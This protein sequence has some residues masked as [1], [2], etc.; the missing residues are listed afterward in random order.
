MPPARAAHEPPRRLGLRGPRG[1][2]EPRCP[3]QAGA[4]GSPW[5][6]PPARRSPAPSGPGA[7]PR[8]ALWV[9]PPLRNRFRMAS[10]SPG[11][12]ATKLPRG[13]SVL[14][15]RT[16]SGPPAVGWAHAA[17]VVARR[18][19][20][21]TGRPAAAEG[22]S[23]ENRLQGRRHPLRP[24]GRPAL[25]RHL[26][27]L[28]PDKQGKERLGPASHRSRTVS[29]HPVKAGVPAACPSGGP[30]AVAEGHALGVRGRTP[31]QGLWLFRSARGERSE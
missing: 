18:R 15:E 30:G 2:G 4:A 23:H 21:E 27:F 22:A 26:W 17:A 31:E 29:G 28:C 10:G 8:P 3:R 16:L 20:H 7:E 5:R 13:L 6:A 24:R 14:E 9:C 19:T 1:P 11:P 25:C 12:A